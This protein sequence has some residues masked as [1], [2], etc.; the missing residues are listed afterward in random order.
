L[1][2]VPICVVQGELNAEVIKS[3]LEA[4]GIPA[5]LKFETYF[6]LQVGAFCPVSVLVPLKYAEIAKEIIKP[7][8]KNLVMTI[9]AKN[10][11][12][13]V[14]ARLFSLLFFNQ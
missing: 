7:S 3:R 11:W 10:K 13:F 2:L 1:E 14:L 6:S 5:M 4:E 9:P 8:D 12:T